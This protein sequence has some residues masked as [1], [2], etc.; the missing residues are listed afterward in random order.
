L[1]AGV[2]GNKKLFYKYINCEKRAKENLHPL[3]DTVGNVTTENKKE[4]EVLNTFFIPVFKSQISYFPGTL[5]L[6]WKSWM[7]S[8]INPHDS[9]RD[10]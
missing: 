4:A 8:K 1:A 7:E 6:A 9:S 2:K 3:L 5:P 10:S